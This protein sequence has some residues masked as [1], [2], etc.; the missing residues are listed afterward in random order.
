M[1]A[2]LWRYLFSGSIGLEA[3]AGLYFIPYAYPE[4]MRFGIEPSIDAP[5]GALDLSLGAAAAFYPLSL[6]TPSVR[7]RPFIH[8]GLISDL[9]VAFATG[10]SFPPVAWT[11]RGIG[12]MG[13]RYG[14]R[15]YSMAVAISFISPTILSL[16]AL[17]G[18]ESPMALR[19]SAEVA[20]PW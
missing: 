16:G 19:L 6:L 5:G 7:L 18:T 14:W 4:F 2:G 3:S 9:S 13:L 15:G 11:L 10:A 20:L 12:G 1:E 8:A 17:Q